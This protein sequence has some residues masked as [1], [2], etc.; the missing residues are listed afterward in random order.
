MESLKSRNFFVRREACVAFTN[1]IHKLEREK[2]TELITEKDTK[3]FVN[4][5]S[6]SYTFTNH[7]EIMTDILDSFEYLINEGE[8][9]VRYNLV[10]F[11][12][13]FCN[14]EELW[15]RAG[16]HGQNIVAFKIGRLL[17]IKS[18]TEGQLQE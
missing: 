6:A 9:M 14:L 18:V 11:A 17:E 4:F 8:F 2:L 13:L 7:P 5:I 3:A 12:D 10:I 1:L 16:N 15:G